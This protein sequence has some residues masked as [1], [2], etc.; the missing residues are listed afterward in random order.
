MTK[1]SSDH[2]AILVLTCALCTFLVVLGRAQVTQDEFN[3][4]ISANVD[5]NRQRL[6]AQ[7]RRI[8]KIESVVNWAAGGLVANL[9]AHVVQISTATRKRREDD[10]ERP[11]VSER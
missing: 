11:R 7:D 1:R 4:R 6:D 2:V 5:A 3:G 10:D 8:D 9:I